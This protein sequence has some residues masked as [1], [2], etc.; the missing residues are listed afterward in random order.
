MPG[1]PRRPEPSVP[2]RDPRQAPEE[3]RSGRRR[4]SRAPAGSARC[5][6][7]PARHRRTLA[8]SPM[9]VRTG[10]V[11]P[12]K[13]L[14]RSPVA[15]AAHENP[16]GPPTVTKPATTNTPITVLPPR[17]TDPNAVVPP[18]ILPP[19]L[20]MNYHATTPQEDDLTAVA[21][22]REL[23][24]ALDHGSPLGSPRRRPI[25]QSPAPPTISSTAP[26]PNHRSGPP[27]KGNVPPTGTS[28]R[29][30]VAA[31]ALESVVSIA[32]QWNPASGS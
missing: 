13:W 30:T 20:P 6:T 28:G 24:Q 27:V 25:N 21:P 23:A 12:D 1:A 29:A 26:P 10:I 9:A 14:S 15:R 7:W 5:S 8:Q 18:P 3:S 31:A 19:E 16:G 4:G 32:V 17:A 11:T 22:N 2:K